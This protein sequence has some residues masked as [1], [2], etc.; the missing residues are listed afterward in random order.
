M[1]QSKSLKK[2]ICA[3]LGGQKHKRVFGA[4]IATRLRSISSRLY[5]RRQNRRSRVSSLRVATHRSRAGQ[6][7]PHPR[8]EKKPGRAAVSSI[9][10][11]IHSQ[12]LKAAVSPTKLAIVPHKKN[13]K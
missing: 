7:V 3:Q 9:L 5:G 13:R 8:S 12:L 4:R 1:I 2:W 10:L 11:L 6:Q